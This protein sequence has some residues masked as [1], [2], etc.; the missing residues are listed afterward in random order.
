MTEYHRPN[1]ILPHQTDLHHKTGYHE[2]DSHVSLE[3]SISSI[4]SLSE[5]QRISPVLSKSRLNASYR[6]AAKSFINRR[7]E[8][9]FTILSEISENAIILYNNE[10]IKETLF[11]NVW[12]LYFNLIDMLINKNEPLSITLDQQKVEALF[13]SDDLFEQLERLY[14][15]VHPKLMV[16]LLLIKLN[17]TATDFQKLRDRIDYYLVNHRVTDDTTPEF[18]DF[19]ELLEL[20]HVFLLGKL[21]EFKEAESLIRSNPLIFNPQ[22]MIQKVQDNKKK[23]EE[24]KSQRL[25]LAKLKKQQDLKAKQKA[26]ELLNKKLNDAKK[27]EQQKKEASLSTSQTKDLHDDLLGRF[28]TLIKAKLSN[29]SITLVL[30]ISMISFLLILQKN[31]WLLNTKVRR[32][33]QQV[34]DKVFSTFKMAF[35]ITYL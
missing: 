32:Y 2:Q 29:K 31:K 12:S 24:E 25:K 20:Y 7:F 11:V 4:L 13:F 16:Q 21:G 34:W 33:I 6:K 9:S 18:Q 3:D 35:S 28:L 10:Q 23:L 5:K 17:N 22:E 15:P 14:V 8:E 27:L 26:Q 1:S 30:I 19:Q